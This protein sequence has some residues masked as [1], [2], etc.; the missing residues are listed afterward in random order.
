MVPFYRDLVG[1]ELKD[2]TKTTYAHALVYGAIEIH[3]Q[4]SRGCIAS[5]KVLAEEGCVKLTTLKKILSQ[6]KTNH[7]ININFKHDDNGLRQRT[8]I[9]P[10]LT[11]SF[12]NC[13]SS[14][15]I[16]DE[17]DEEE[18]ED[19][20]VDDDSDDNID[21]NEE[22]NHNENSL[23]SK[24]VLPISKIV[25]PN[26]IYID[27]SI[28]NN[29]K[30]K[31][32]KRKIAS[33]NSNNDFYNNCQDS[34]NPDSNEDKMAR[35]STRG[36]NASSVLQTTSIPPTTPVSPKDVNSV[37]KVFYEAYGDPSCF[38]NVYARNCAKKLVEVYG[39]TETLEM[40]R[41]ATKHSGV[42]KYAPVVSGPQALLSKWHNVKA[43]QKREKQ[44]E[45]DEKREKEKIDEIDTEWTYDNLTDKDKYDFLK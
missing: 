2:G 28:D 26:S 22:N 12:K 43:Y 21:K 44:K 4:G 19:D 25:I 33:S 29:I 37:L 24:T 39:A 41:Y 20:D 34:N 11:I 6:F 10:L 16:D 31:Y 38:G 14:H 36:A 23:S 27:N 5:N 8:T 40:A 15:K 32:I 45:E 13:I 7:W 17:V 30:E 35:S 1:I 3:S 42:D 9:E 18:Y